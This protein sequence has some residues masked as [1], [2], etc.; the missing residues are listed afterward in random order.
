MTGRAPIPEDAAGPSGRRRLCVY[1]GGFLTQKR[2]RRILDL[3]GYDVRIG[4][5]GPEDMIGIWGRSPTAPRGE[6]IA[7]RR[8]APVLRIE[9]AFLRSV[10]PGRI[11]A[12]TGGR[13]GSPP[14]GLLLDRRG[15]HFDSS[16]PSDLEL[17]LATAPLDDTVLLD[18]AR[19]ATRRIRDAHLSKYNNFDPGIP[20]PD[21]PYVL[22]ID[23]TRDDASI[24]HG[25]AGAAT[26]RDMLVCAQVEHPGN[27]IVIKTHP[28]TAAGL[29][30]GHFG[31]PDEN[32]RV[33]LI[34]TPV[35]PWRLFECATAVYTV[36]SQMGFE[37]IM[38]G[39]R[40]HVF[41]QPFYAG[42]GLTEDRNPVSRRHR[43]LTRAQLFAAAMILYPV[44]YDPCRDRLCE[45]EDAL[46]QLEA[47]ARAWRDDH[48]GHVAIGMRRWKHACL[49]RFHGHVRPLVH[50]DDTGRA[51]ALARAEGRDLLV[52]AS[53][54]SPDLEPA[55]TAAGLRLRR[56]EDGFLRSR[57]LGA[58]LV[59]PLSLV[60]D[61]TGI[62]YDPTRP[63]RLE[64]LI[65]ESTDLPAASLRRAETLIERLKTLGLGKYNLHA[66]AP[67]SDL[68]ADW[69][70]SEGRRVILVPGQVEDDASVLHG[71][72]TAGAAR[73]E[74]EDRQEDDGVNLGLLARCRA[75]NPEALILYKPHPDV[76]AGL[77]RGAVATADALR[78][79]DA[80]LVNADPVALIGRVDEVWTLTSLLGFEALLR[81][82]PV[83]CLGA[84]FYAGWGL[85]RDLGAVP[86]R[87][88]GRHGA[89]K[90]GLAGL[91]HA[92]LIDYPRYLDP[93]TGLP[94]PVEVIVERLASGETGRQGTT[95]R[96][97]SLLQRLRGLL[98]R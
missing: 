38:A 1:N 84:P 10:L 51:V 68:P 86:A 57:G 36:S 15:V 39:H 25:G 56:V 71:C 16:A 4:L 82:C 11:G 40:P 90:V 66:A 94:C 31:K 33:S 65:A 83:T 21:A 14:L 55:A 64:R 23:Q 20:T 73:G 85:T 7:H 12:G 26:F 74:T 79:A 9:D 50:E 8:G 5:P 72:R 2:I 63:S 41:G 17:L 58:R 87:R 46:A 28:E 91:A 32:R 29:R 24:T 42:W 97:L 37:A 61:D 13:A 92:A 70:A 96:V 35:S 3:A 34:D 59:P 18:R 98:A 52:W 81:G 30:P 48:R 62:H 6:R 22:V 27:R 89:A 67:P 88:G 47:E 95:G 77:R 78:H 45:L 93:L 53:R 43:R 60:L 54:E 76:E 80:V 49:E 19:D 69:P 44:W 75:E